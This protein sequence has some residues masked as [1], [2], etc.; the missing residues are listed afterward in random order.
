MNASGL[1]TLLS[2]LAMEIVSRK[3]NTKYATA[4]EEC[5]EN[6]P[7]EDRNDDGLKP[8]RIYCTPGWK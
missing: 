4:T 5:C 3:I 8:K 7:R 2:I 1:G 6:E